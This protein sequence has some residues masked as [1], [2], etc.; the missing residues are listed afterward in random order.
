MAAPTDSRVSEILDNFGI[1]DSGA[2]QEF[3]SGMV[4]DTTEGKINFLSVRFGPMFRRW[5]DHLT[6]GRVK[7]PDVSPGTPN[8]TLASGMEE[9]L[10]AKESAARHFE[11]WLNGERDED[12]AAGVF[13]NINL[14]EYVLERAD[15]APGAGAQIVDEPVAARIKELVERAEIIESARS[16]EQDA[17]LE[18]TR[19]VPN[20]CVS[21]ACPTAHCHTGIEPEE[22]RVRE[23]GEVIQF[24]NPTDMCP[25][26]LMRGGHS[27]PTICRLPKGHTGD[28]IW[29]RTGP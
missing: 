5:A 22:L 23:P 8:W 16:E 20:R 25:T 3:S 13:F 11:S 18:G 19:P 26:I 14:A 15:I 29:D 4:R 2:R 1:K 12:H 9:Y 27:G 24:V 28:H 6:K 17:S 10:R 21:C 7:Y